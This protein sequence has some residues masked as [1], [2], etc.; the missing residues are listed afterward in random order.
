MGESLTTA[1]TLI[2]FLLSQ[3]TSVLSDSPGED[4][5]PVALVGDAHGQRFTFFEGDT[6]E[7]MVENAKRDL[8]DGGYDAWVLAYEGFVTTPGGERRNAFYIHSWVRGLEQPI[9]L[10]QAWKRPLNGGV[11]EWLGPPILL[12]SQ[13]APEAGT[14]KYLAGAALTDE[15]SRALAAGVARNRELREQGLLGK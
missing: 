1:F 9:L 12:P 13:K 11:V 4:L 10:A 14:K 5:T 6:L 8:P 7:E 2:G 3:V 15:Q